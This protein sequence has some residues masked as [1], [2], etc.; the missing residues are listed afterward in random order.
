MIRAASEIGLKT[1]PF[2]GAMVGLQATAIKTELG[3]LLNGVVDYD[4]WLPVGGF[5]T[6]AAMAFLKE[7]QAAA[8]GKG[9]DQLGYYLPPFAYSDLQ[10]VGQA[11]EGTKSLDQRKLAAYIGSHTFKTVV[12]SI[13]FGPNGEWVAPRVLE[14][15]FRGVNGHGLEQFTNP[16]TE[17][18]LWPKAYIERHAP[19]SIYAGATL[20]RSRSRSGLVPRP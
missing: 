7:Y 1:T 11:V 5:A 15:Q 14:V 2:G 13:K 20:N 19:V 4:F 8:K 9:V 17:T 18:I 12:G 6:P 3:P 16:K 10:V